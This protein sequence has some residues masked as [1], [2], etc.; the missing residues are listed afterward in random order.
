MLRGR[1]VYLFFQRNQK[2]CSD[3]AGKND[4]LNMISFKCPSVP[5]SITI[6]ALHLATLQ[7]HLK[8]KLFQ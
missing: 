4:R 7:V 2:L 5:R 8:E 6:V 3:V 1:K